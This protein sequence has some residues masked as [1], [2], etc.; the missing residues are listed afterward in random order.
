M[1]SPF[2]WL[3]EH[4]K[5]ISLQVI[6]VPRSSRSGII[7]P[8]GDRLKIALKAPP[9]YGKAN[10]ELLNLLRKV[11]GIPGTSLHILHGENNRRK[12]ILLKTLS[13]QDTIKSIQQALKT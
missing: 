4:E 10:Q 7:G 1:H 3:A 12:T 11:L 5:G 9:V 8:H 2:P 13:M 6:V